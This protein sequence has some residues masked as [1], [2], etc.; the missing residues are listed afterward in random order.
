MEGNKKMKN[1][2]TVGL[3]IFFLTGCQ[4]TAKL[5]NI[6]IGMPLS[7]VQAM[8]P[9]EKVAEDQDGVV[10]RCWIDGGIKSMLRNHSVLRGNEPY[11]L[12]FSKSDENLVEMKFDESTAI[13]RA[14]SRSNY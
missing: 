13:R 3:F 12:L 9:L 4:Q 1:I 10:Y 6:K 14:S 2:S 8:A 5:D 7:V 11:L